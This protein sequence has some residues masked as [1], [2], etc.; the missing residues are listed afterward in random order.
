MYFTY[1]SVNNVI[2]STNVYKMFELTVEGESTALIF[3][4]ASS[5]KYFFMNILGHREK[6]LVR[7]GPRLFRG[8]G[9]P[10]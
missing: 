4:S 3:E 7:N 5:L 2:F 6:G 10:V 1:N 9:Y 8:A